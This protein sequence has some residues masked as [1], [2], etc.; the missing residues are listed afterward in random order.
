MK[1][2][3]LSFFC[4]LI[5]IM[6]VCPAINA[7][8]YNDVDGT[9]SFAEA[10]E[11]LKECGIMIGDG[12]GIFNPYSSVTR[13]EMATIVCR[14]LDEPGAFATSNTFS[15]VAV[16]HWANKYIT[17][18][19]E[20]GIVK[21]YGGGLFGPND[22]VTYEQAVVMIIRTIGETTTAE[23]LGGYPNG[24]LELAKQMGILEGINS[25]VG[26][27]LSRAEIAIIIYNCLF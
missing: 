24:Y 3:G 12:T 10:V 16:N 27:D 21:G 4:L 2:I 6:F 9:E 22:N 17:K 25:K 8:S 15:D 1:R 23:G 7:S 19:S 18:A 20:F 26:E 5:C 13:A 11:V 14:I